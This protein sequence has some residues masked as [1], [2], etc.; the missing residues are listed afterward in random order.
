MQP[1]AYYEHTYFRVGP[2]RVHGLGV[3]AAREFEIDD[4]VG[5]YTGE[6]MKCAEGSSSNYI[7]GVEWWDKVQCVLQQ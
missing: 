5:V 1:Y 6:C 4:V 2:S 3:F 7:V